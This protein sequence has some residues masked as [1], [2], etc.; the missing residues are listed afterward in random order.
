[1]IRLVCGQIDT[2]HSQCC[3]NKLASWFY[4]IF[5][6]KKQVFQPTCTKFAPKPKF[7]QKENPENLVSGF[8]NNIQQEI[9][10]LC[11]L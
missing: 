7:W 3:Y 11:E 1:M 10:S 4:M 6:F 9:L 2:G 5:A 8:F